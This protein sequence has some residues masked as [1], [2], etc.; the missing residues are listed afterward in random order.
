MPG[1][2]RLKLWLDPEKLA[3]EVFQ[4]RG[5]GDDQI[6]L[7]LGR[8]RGRIL[9]GGQEPV[10]QVGRPLPEVFEERRVEPDESVAAVEVAEGEAVPQDQGG[11]GQ[12]GGYRGKGGRISCTHYDCLLSFWDPVARRRTNRAGGGRCLT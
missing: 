4:V 1:L 3:D 11:T 6:R 12:G 9:S 7:R 5:H 2:E 10:A 8:Q